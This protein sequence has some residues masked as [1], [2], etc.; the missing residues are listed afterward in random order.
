VCDMRVLRRHDRKTHQAA[1]GMEVEIDAK[2]AKSE[3]EDKLSVNGVRTILQ[4]LEEQGRRMDELA[5]HVERLEQGLLR[6]QVFN[7]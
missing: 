6:E 1:Q 5:R 2:K 7:T 3:A 4:V